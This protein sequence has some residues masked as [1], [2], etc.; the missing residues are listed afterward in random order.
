MLTVARTGSLRRE[1]RGMAIV[2]ACLVVGTALTRDG[3]FTVVSCEIIRIA[4]ATTV[5]FGSLTGWRSAVDASFAVLAHCAFVH[6]FA[7]GTGE[8]GRAIAH[9]ITKRY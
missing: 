2:L 7:E 6:N 1:A 4:S 5:V 8:S 9:A 3:D